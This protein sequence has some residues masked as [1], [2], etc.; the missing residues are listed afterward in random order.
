MGC[1]SILD[2]FGG[3][4][5]ICQFYMNY[6]TVCVVIKLGEEVFTG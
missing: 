4:P 3:N 5:Y 6:Q 1:M 2:I